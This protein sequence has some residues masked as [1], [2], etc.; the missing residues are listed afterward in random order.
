MAIGSLNP[1]IEIWDL[2]IVDCLEP[3]FILGSQK[4]IKKKLPAGVKKQKI[5]GHRGPVLSLAWNNANKTVL[6]SGSTDKS[7]ILWDLQKLKLAT[8][9]KNHTDNVQSLQWHPIE[10]FSLLSGSADKTV[11]MYDCRNPNTNK[12]SW[13]LGAEVEEVTWNKFDPNYFLVSEI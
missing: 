8:R 9:I 12:K 13:S 10:L 6:A 11:C 1:W 4:K 2:D 7:I 5:L 3:E